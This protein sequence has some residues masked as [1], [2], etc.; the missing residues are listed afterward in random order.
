MHTILNANTTLKFEKG[1][2]EQ[3]IVSVQKHLYGLTAAIA[4][5]TAI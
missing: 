4:Y 2:I 3:R 5:C 1:M